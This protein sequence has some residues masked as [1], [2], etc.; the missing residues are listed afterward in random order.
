LPKVRCV[1]TEQEKDDQQREQVTDTAAVLQAEL[2]HFA[3]RERQLQTRLDKMKRDA[4]QLRMQF[5]QQ[6]KEFDD[7]KR[8]TASRWEQ[9]MKQR[10]STFISLLSSVS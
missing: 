6:S 2:I 10:S 1:E 3:D 4:N 8:N 7:F 9:E 5:E